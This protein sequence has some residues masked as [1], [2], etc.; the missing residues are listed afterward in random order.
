MS[1]R[2]NVCVF[3]LDFQDVRLSVCTRPKG[4]VNLNNVR[5]D[6][7][8]I[9]PSIY[10]SIHPSIYPSLHTVSTEQLKHTFI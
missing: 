2:S 8:S 5:L 1:V 4:V 9:H 3:W 7:P 6:Y 10:P